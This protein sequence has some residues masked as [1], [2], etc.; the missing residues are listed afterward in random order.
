MWRQ[1]KNNAMIK[2]GLENVCVLQQKLG[3]TNGKNLRGIK[4]FWAAYQPSYFPQ[5]N[6]A[7]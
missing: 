2:N 6:Q 4:D 1:M 3:G 7:C 5:I